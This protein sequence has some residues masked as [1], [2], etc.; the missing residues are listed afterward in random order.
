MQ[1]IIYLQYFRRM[2]IEAYTAYRRASRRRSSRTPF[3]PLRSIENEV[4]LTGDINAT[5]NSDLEDVGVK[6]R[7]E[8]FTDLYTVEAELGRL[9]QVVIVL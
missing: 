5:D 6:I 3:N 7:T 4:E 8:I 9:V 2:S 1:S